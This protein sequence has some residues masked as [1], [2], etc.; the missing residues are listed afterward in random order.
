MQYYKFLYF[1]VSTQCGVLSSRFWPVRVLIP[2][3]VLQGN[4]RRVNG[5]IPC[6]R[7]GSRLVLYD[8]GNAVSSDLIS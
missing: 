3:L 5:N 1:S 2:S 4:H 8:H 7:R 6:F